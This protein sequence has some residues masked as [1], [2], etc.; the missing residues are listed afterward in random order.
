[1]NGLSIIDYYLIYTPIVS[2]T[3]LLGVIIDNKLKF[4]LNSIDV[5]RKIA[6]KVRVLLKSAFDIEFKTMLFKLF[7][8]S[9]FD[10][11][12]SLFV[13]FSSQVDKLRLERSYSNGVFSLLRVNLYDRNFSTQNSTMMSLERQLKTLINFNILP[14]KFRYFRRL[15]RFLFMDITIRIRDHH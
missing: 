7:I 13:H 10:Y 3:K 9:T 14:L 5:T 1:V 8:L 4:D 11:C 2:S 15:I 12:S 6:Y